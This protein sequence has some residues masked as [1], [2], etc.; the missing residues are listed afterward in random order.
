V[1]DAWREEEGIRS[2]LFQKQIFEIES[3]SHKGFTSNPINQTKGN[4]FPETMISETNEHRAEIISISLRKE[5][6]IDYAMKCREEELTK[7]G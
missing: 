6:K 3:V 5:T 2:K 7:M 1:R 4:S